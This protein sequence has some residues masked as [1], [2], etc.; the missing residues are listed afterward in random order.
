MTRRSLSALVCAATLLG[1]S[2]AIAGTS[3]ATP[4]DNTP[5]GA[6]VGDIT[7]WAPGVTSSSF[8]DVGQTGPSGDV[9]TYT[10]SRRYD[11]ATI[12]STTGT[13]YLRATSDVGDA[14]MVETKTASQR[15]VQIYDASA[16]PA[17]RVLDQTFPCTDGT[18]T[19]QA[20]PNL[21]YVSFVLQCTVAG[22]GPQGGSDL[23]RFTRV[24]DVG[25]TPHVVYTADTTDIDGNY[26]DSWDIQPSIGRWSGDQDEIIFT[27][28][29][30]D[31][32]RSRHAVVVDLQQGTSHTWQ[33]GELTAPSTGT[34]EYQGG[35]TPCGTSFVTV[36]NAVSGTTTTESVYR[37]RSTAT[38]AVLGSY[39]LPADALYLDQVRIAADGTVDGRLVGGSTSGRVVIGT[40]SAVC[41][42]HLATPVPAWQAGS[43]APHSFDFAGG[44]TLSWPALAT[45]DVGVTG[46]E[47][48]DPV[49]QPSGHVIGRVSGAGTTSFVLPDTVP[50]T[51]A[52]FWVFALDA[53]GRRSEA[54]NGSYYNLQG[55]PGEVGTTPTP[56]PTP[57]PSTGP[58]PAKSMP[59]SWIAH[60][61]AKHGKAVAGKTVRVSKPVF[62]AAGR[63][64]GLRAVYQW[65]AGSKALKGAT[66]MTLKIKKAFRHKVIAVRVTITKPGYQSRS[67]KI[68][69]GRAR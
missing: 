52:A 23:E 50:A 29:L 68:G 47:I 59:L 64:Q 24:L 58:A 66:S 37:L 32:T 20:S 65:Y 15:Q 31:A 22:S 39:T 12:L 51:D 7:F 13:G 63:S 26:A 43:T 38:G 69:F 34:V 28:G 4:A 36:D 6:Q 9:Y 55:T 56:T 42:D 67:K 17:L 62:S 35:F 45:D 53:D 21:R 54:L 5:G 41:D 60:W 44:R 49:P 46:Y 10:V 25:R 40:D 11:S 57:S 27:W 48:L 8:T 1:G 14:Y 30:S 19:I 3:N 16:D 2:F 33:S 18:P 61:P